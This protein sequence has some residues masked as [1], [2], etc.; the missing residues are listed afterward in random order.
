MS[1]PGTGTTG[2]KNLDQQKNHDAV[3]KPSTNLTHAN[4]RGTSSRNVTHSYGLEIKPLGEN[5]NLT[6]Y[7]Q[8]STAKL[9]GSEFEVGSLSKKEARS[10]QNKFTYGAAPQ[11]TEV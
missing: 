6:N 2:I 5:K 10:S 9:G 11:K 1:T 8:K 4:K 3:L 7:T